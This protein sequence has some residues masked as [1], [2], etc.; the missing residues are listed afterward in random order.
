MS[1]NK[2]SNRKGV[3]YSTNPN[4]EYEN[5]NTEK[6]NVPKHK[7]QLYVHI[8]KK[9]S[10]KTAIAIKGFKCE[11]NKIKDLG[12]ILKNKCGVGGT[13]KNNEIIIQGNI[14]NKIILLL[15]SEGY[16]CKKSGG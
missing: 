6:E 8:D 15:E 10:G 9:R 14:R 1:I 13:V 5:E 12:R 3:V 4:Y 11:I 16:K 2:K 7:Q